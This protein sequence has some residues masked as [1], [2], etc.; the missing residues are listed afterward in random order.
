MKKIYRYFFAAIA[1]AS[2]A[3]CAEQMEDNST[4]GTQN[5]PAEFAQMTISASLGE[6][7]KTTYEDQSVL[8]EGTESITVFSKGSEGTPQEFDMTWCSEDKAEAAFSGLADLN[9]E[10]Y[11]AVYPHSATNACTAEGVLTV[12]IPSAQTAVAGGF[13]SGANVSVAAWQKSDFESEGNIIF[14]NVC[15]LLSFGFET[16]AD[17][18]LTQSVT[19]RMKDETGYINIAGNVSV[20]YN[21]EGDLVVS[22]GTTDNIVLTA[23]TGGFVKGVTYY[24]LVAPVGQIA[25]MELTY[26]HTDGTTTCTRKNSNIIASL[27]RSTLVPLDIIPVAYDNLPQE[28]FQVTVDFTAGWPFEE[29]IVPVAQQKASQVDGNWFVGYM[30]TLKDYE[31]KDDEGNTIATLSGLKSGIS[32]GKHATGYVHHT[33]S[34]GGVKSLYFYKEGVEETTQANYVGLITFPKIEGRYMKSV[35][36]Y[37]NSQ[38]AAKWC[39]ADGWPVIGN[40]QTSSSSYEPNTEYTYNFPIKTVPITLETVYQFR[41]RSYNFNLTKFTVTYSKNIPTK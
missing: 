27:S 38:G 41:I 13:A 14:N 24:V 19:V 1:I 21:P 16:D 9:A 34:A 3:A 26:T 20:S 17:A 7:T 25:E 5:A 29:D 23:P 22:E 15:T 36:G 12:N 33:P 4:L 28:D 35:M 40:N 6:V 2:A 32:V 11:Y 31:L 8:W 30:Y 37:H 39:P 10:T 18:V